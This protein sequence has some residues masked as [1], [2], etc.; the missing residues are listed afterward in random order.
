[1]L[2][3]SNHINFLTVIDD[4]LALEMPFTCLT[5]IVSSSFWAHHFPNLHHRYCRLHRP[6]CHDHVHD[7]F[8]NNQCTLIHC[9]MFLNH[10]RASS[11]L[12][13]PQHRYSHCTTWIHHAR[14]FCHQSTG[15]H[16]HYCPCRSFFRDSVYCHC[17]SNQYTCHLLAM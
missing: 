1:M 9:D 8:S 4:C 10:V 5:T 13:I 6:F 14:A 16:K 15:H 11:H 12:P 2:L 3:S 17:S 7:H